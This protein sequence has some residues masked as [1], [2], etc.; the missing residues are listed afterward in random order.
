[1][2]SS[3]KKVLYIVNSVPAIR[4][5]PPFQRIS[6]LSKHFEVYVLSLYTDAP[7]ELKESGSFI[8]NPFS[9][10]KWFGALTFPL[11]CLWMTFILRDKSFSIVMTTPKPL[12]LFSGFL[13][14]LFF[15][16][17]W[18][19]DIYDVPNLRLNTFQKKNGFKNTFDFKATRF[20]DLVIQHILKKSDLV[21]CTL[22]PEALQPYKIPK[23]KI[24]P[25]TN[26]TDLSFLEKFHTPYIPEDKPDKNEDC[27]VLYIG[28]VVKRKGL[29]TI[30]DAARRLKNKQPGIKWLLIGPSETEDIRW[31]QDALSRDNLGKKVKWTGELPHNKAL[32]HIASSDICLFLFPRN[33]YTNYIFPLKIFE[34]MGFGKAIVASDLDGV[35]QVLTNEESAILITPENTC[36]L[37]QTVERLYQDHDL[38]KKI[39][40]N[41]KTKSKQY[42]WELI[43]QI[44]RLHLVKLA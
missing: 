13:I 4:N 9:R 39:S 21:L 42:D 40:K 44:I 20:F 34:Y 5:Y 12:Q 43:N 11:W 31:M 10:L 18:V 15:K 41:A 23:E 32:Q 30:I 22:I 33:Y 2:I 28:Y 14:K 7:D 26:G 3:K 35:K 16:I 29:H 27:V 38:R 25:L 1:M 17:N 6:F 36:A 8:K 19:A 37:A 24:V